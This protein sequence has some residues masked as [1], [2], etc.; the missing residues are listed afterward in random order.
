MSRSSLARSSMAPLPWETRL[1]VTPSASAAASTASSTR[2][3]STLGISMRNAAPS[4]KVPV[5]ACWPVPAGRPVL[6]GSLRPRSPSS[7]SIHVIVPCSRRSRRAPVPLVPVPIVPAGRPERQRASRR[8]TAIS[9]ASPNDCA[10]LIADSGS[11]AN[12]VIWLRWVQ[13]DA[14]AEQ[15]EAGAAVHLALDRLDLVDGALDLARAVGEGEAVDDGFLVVA[16]PGG[17][18]R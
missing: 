5:L 10:H 6:S 17:E 16:D 1:T 15:G 14:L 11:A 7:P 3:P 2:G 13:H 9:P 8:I 12:Y 4:G 18:D